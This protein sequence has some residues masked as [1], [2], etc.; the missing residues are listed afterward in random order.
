MQRLAGF[1]R[2]L[3]AVLYSQQRAGHA[4]NV[5]D[6]TVHSAV[7]AFQNGIPSEL[8]RELKAHEQK[9][10]FWTSSDA[11]T[12]KDNFPGLLGF[13][14]VPY[15]QTWV[16]TS[17]KVLPSG[18]HFFTPVVDKI[19][20]IKS[21]HTIVSG[22]FSEEVVAKNG[23]TVEAYAVVYFKVTDFKKS[24]FY[25]DPETNK[26]DSERTLAKL[27]QRLLAREIG[28]VT[29]SETGT[30]SEADQKTLNEKLT[31][32]LKAK[33]SELGLSI[34]SVEVRG[35]FPV[36]LQ[37]PV[38]VRAL[39]APAPAPETV[40]HS[41]SND[42]WADALTPPFFEKNKFGGRKEDKTPATVSL[43]WSIPSPP[44][45][46][47]FN[48]IPRACVNPTETSVEKA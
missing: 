27:T 31:S 41:L 6:Y 14:L 34:E 37:V 9:W 21:S 43:V 3:P 32:S 26:V 40:G 44:D 20:A 19:K 13:K 23:K 42:Y 48:H 39:E 28:N 24:T 7:T 35:A 12:P 25:L 18:Y 46:H 10:D 17:G 22:V 2:R 38:K 1:S 33:E 5:P 30:L 16:L 45:F 8:V 36:E 15:G 11:F 47:H 4:L 29:A